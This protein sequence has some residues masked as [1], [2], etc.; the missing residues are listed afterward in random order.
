M[1][2][3]PRPLN[4]TFSLSPAVSPLAQDD[5]AALSWLAITTPSLRFT[6][7][8]EPAKNAGPNRARTLKRN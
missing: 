6:E 5:A 2:K 4:V 3:D 8:G 1:Q 7:R